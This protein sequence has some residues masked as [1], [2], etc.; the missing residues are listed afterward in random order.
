MA[1]IIW[2]P[3]I[4]FIATAYLYLLSTRLPEMDYTGKNCTSEDLKFPRN[5]QELTSLAVLLQQ[6]KTDHLP[7]VLL[8][9]CSAYLYKQSFAIPGSVFMNL[10]AGALFPTWLGFII[11]C[12]LSACG[13]TF[14][15]TWS[16]LCGKAYIIRY[17]PDKVKFLQQKVKENMDSLFYFL[18]F[19]RFFPM[20]PNW[21]LNMASPI[22]D[23]PV[24]MFFFSVFIG[25]VPYNFIC[26]QTGSM[27]SDLRSIEDIFTLWTMAKLGLIAI[28][29]LVPGLVTKRLKKDIKTD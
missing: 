29:A 7:Y 12:T 10:L 23:I 5:L 20:T 3:V 26:V 9:F 8:L 14:C 2:L 25:L 1:S 4:V 19:L 22:V 6:Y 13:A 21:F 15:Y 24:H 17:F 28:M 16:K 11:V 18:L 27:L